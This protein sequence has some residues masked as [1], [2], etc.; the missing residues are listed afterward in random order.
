VAAREEKAAADDAKSQYWLGTELEAGRCGTRDIERSQKLLRRSASRNFPP[1]VHVIG[2]I[3]RREGQSNAALVQFEKAADLGFQLG[4][5]DMGFTLGASNLPVY[6]P[7]QAFAWLSLALSRETSPRLQTYLEKSLKARADSMSSTE[8][9][10]ARA[11]LEELKVRYA[12]VP[13]WQD[14]Q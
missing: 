11:K 10:R 9:E 6:E 14:T 2:V 13:R 3:L 8:L 4:F 7:I 5:V 12:A 1:A